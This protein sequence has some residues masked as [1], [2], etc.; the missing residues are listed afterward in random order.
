MSE[1]TRRVTTVDH[2][3]GR[4]GDARTE[5]AGNVLTAERVV[6][7]PHES[8]R[9]GDALQHLIDHDHC[10]DA[11]GSAKHQRAAVVIH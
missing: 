5:A 1:Y 8:C 4:G 10:V 11:V 9:H 6:S 7:P 3:Q 2:F